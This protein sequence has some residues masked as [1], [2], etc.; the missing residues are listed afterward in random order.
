MYEV[1]MEKREW[2]AGGWTDC[3]QRVMNKHDHIK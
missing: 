1:E 2:V 3:E